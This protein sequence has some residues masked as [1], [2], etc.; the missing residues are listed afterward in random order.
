MTST[1]T[2]PSSSPRFVIR[3]TQ[4]S[5]NESQRFLIR[6]E[7]Q[8]ERAQAILEFES[9][10]R[11]EKTSRPAVASRPG[12]SELLVNAESLLKAGE[13]ST[14][15]HLVRQA[16]C[17]DSRHP[18]ALKKMIRCLGR[19]EWDRQQKT[20]ILKTLTQVEPTFENYAFYGQELIEAGDLDGALEAFF[21][22]TLRVQEESDL[23]F[24]VYKNIGNIY[25]R[26]GDFESAEESYHKAFTLKPDSDVLQVNL[27]TLAVQKQD[28]ASAIE[29]FR[30]SL[31][32]NSLND[33]AWVG[34]ALCHH[35]VG[36]AHLSQA[37]LENALDICPSNRTAVHLMASW[38]LQAGSIERAVER[39]QDYLATQE[40][41][42]EMS[43]V[44]I[45]LFCHKGQYK[46]A[47]L[48]LER[49]MCWEPNR[50][51]LLELKK[52]FSQIAE[53]PL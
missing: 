37:T 52:Q 44:L 30:K 43:L 17:L 14:A 4:T 15:A 8:R 1:E 9:E 41:D 18:E 35:Q 48:E 27:G 6:P 33:K 25:V 24:E 39:L 13:K 28:W 5:S 29:R 21:E 26:K 31:E 51:D 10:V 16:L 45:H 19:Q 11:A 34:L 2:R 46:M 49:A 40:S 22:A 38:S 3:E 53:E 42:V 36:E 7:N 50:E 23:L 20:V 47:Q 32:I 12:I